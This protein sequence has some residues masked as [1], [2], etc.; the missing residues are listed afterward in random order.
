[1]LNTSKKIVAFI[2]VGLTL[3]GSVGLQLHVAACLHSGNE[4]ISLEA[5]DCCHE[6]DHSTEVVSEKCCDYRD[7]QVSFDSF[8]LNQTVKKITVQFDGCATLE[9]LTTQIL[10]SLLL[11]FTEYVLPPPLLQTDF[12]V[13]FQVFRL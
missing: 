1:M 12:Q 5:F 3:L 8:R 10:P 6:G 9:G 2:L 11:N 13:L 4:R 7:Y